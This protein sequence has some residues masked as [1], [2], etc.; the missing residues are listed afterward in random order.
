MFLLVIMANYRLDIEYDGTNMSGWQVQP[1]ARSVQGDIEKVLSLLT[2]EKIK[3]IGAG[4]TDAG[5]H[6]YGQVANFH[7]EGE[8]DIQKLH[9]SLN[10]VLSEDIAIKRVSMVPSVFHARYSAKYRQYMY[11]ICA[12]KT[13]INRN[14]QWILSYRV[15][16]EIV[17]NLLSCLEG[18][19]DFNAFCSSGSDTKN[20]VCDIQFVSL[21]QKNGEMVF[22]IRANRFLYKMVRSVVGTLVDIGRGRLSEDVLQKAI[23]TGNRFLVGNTAPADGL[24]LVEVGY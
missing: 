21:E 11:R 17:Q 12:K 18:E 15:D 1:N 22:H 9:R 4:R 14:Y 5:V 24:A 6:A 10:A 2:K 19:H 7:T 8:L 23:S 13:A 20:K 16:W 3:I